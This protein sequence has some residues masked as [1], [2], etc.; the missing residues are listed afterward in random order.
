MKKSKAGCDIVILGG[1]NSDFVVRG[2]SL[3][4]EGQTTPGDSFYSGPGGKGANQAVAAARLGAR[5]AFVGRVG[6]DDR[7]RELV[8]GLRK[9]GIDVRHVASDARA[10]TGA[11]IIAVDEKGEKQISAFSG[12]N[13]RVSLAQVESAKELI[14]SARVLLMQFEV[15]M[16]CVVRAAEIARKHGTKV[17]LDPA[18]PAPIPA[19]LFSLLEIIRPNLDEAQKM[20]GRAIKNPSDARSAA[21]ALLERGVKM[22]AMESGEKGDLVVTDGAEILLP[23]LKVKTVD[24]TGAG[25]AFA[26]AL[27]VGLAEG[28]NLEEMARL[29]NATAALATTKVGAQEGMPSRSRA[30]WL[31][32]RAQARR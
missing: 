16:P 19:K 28:L 1:I 20:V 4:T 6:K 26:A 22:V 24:A 18:P 13:G 3:P 23:R 7:G 21:K 27:A 12:A 30:E 9:E 8:A 25:D 5:V 17:V 32:R 31:M 10:Q 15:P 2:G 14:A 29:A 11:A